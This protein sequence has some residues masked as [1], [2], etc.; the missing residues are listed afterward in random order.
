M[1]KRTKKNEAHEKP[2]HQHNAEIRPAGTMKTKP[3]EQHIH[4][5]PTG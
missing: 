3:S 5:G 2:Y 4:N 1:V